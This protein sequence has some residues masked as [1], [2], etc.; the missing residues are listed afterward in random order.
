MAFKFVNKYTKYDMSDIDGVGICDISGFM[1]KRKDMRK[2]MEWRG[3]SL[4]WTGLMV[5]IPYLDQPNEQFRPPPIKDDP[6]PIDNPRPPYPYFDPTSPPVTPYP[7]I[8]EEL[9]AD[10]FHNVEN[11]SFG[12]PNE[13]PGWPNDYDVPSY[14][15]VLEQLRKVTFQ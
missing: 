12:I 3:D 4:V 11:P 8:L 15:V 9:D 6:K 1:F 7:Q 10:T 5:G 13:V 2:Q 14:S